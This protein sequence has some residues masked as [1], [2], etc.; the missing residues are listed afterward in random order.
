MN[1]RRDASSEEAAFRSFF[2]DAYGDVERFCSRR[3]IDGDVDAVV[4]EAFLTAWTCWDRRPFAPAELRPWMFG[5]ARN[6]VRS[7]QRREGTRPGR[8]QHAARLLPPAPDAFEA[9]TADLELRAAL[10]SLS[11]SDREVLLLVAWDD[12][13]MRE[14]AEVLGVSSVAA[15]VRLHRARSRL[16]QTLAPNRTVSASTAF[17]QQK[18]PQ[19]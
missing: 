4:G 2:H 8:E 9:I 5:I 18:G 11:A 14:L 1:E 7:T 3:I 15:R 16:R 19:T 12:C 10:A 13:D 6:L 17:E